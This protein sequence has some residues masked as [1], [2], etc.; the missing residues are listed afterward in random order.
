MKIL[1]TGG[2]GQLGTSLQ[3]VLPNAMF[4]GS[5]DLDITNMYAV[6]NFVQNNDVDTIINCAAYTRV[7]D[8]EK[9]YRNANRINNYGVRNLAGTKCN[10]IHISTDYVFDGKATKPYK[11]DDTLNPLSIYG[12]TKMKG[13]FSA[14]QF[15]QPVVVIRTSW[16]YSNYGKNFFKT[17]QRLGAEKDFINVVSD[18]FGT[19]TY[20]PD[21]AKAI[22][23][24]IPQMNLDNKGIYHYSNMG[25]CSWYEF[26]SEIMNLS[27]LKC[28]VNPIPTSQ[29]PTPAKRPQ[30]SV[31]D[32]TKI[33]ETFGLQIPNWQDAL[34]RCIKSKNK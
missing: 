2:T 18:Q 32:K 4:V 25:A 34:I 20:A 6:R 15:D 27:G 8:A 7:D 22:V 9:D 29:Y 31:L 13:E 1:V 11:E 10:L 23:D 19:P 14:L 33:K 26:A 21:L 30:Y 17:M 5:K 12:Y 3:D 24:I 28:N 16:L